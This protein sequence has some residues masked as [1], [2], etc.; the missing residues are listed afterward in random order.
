MP[1]LNEESYRFWD[2]VLKASS[3][4]G[5]ILAALFSYNQYLDTATRDARKPFLEKQ[6]EL[7]VEAADS[8]ATIATS[9]ESSDVEASKARFDRL[10]WGSLAIFDNQAIA[11]AM[12]RFNSAVTTQ[13]SEDDFA[14]NKAFRK[15]L[16]PLSE[17]I[18]HECR[19]L[20][21][22]SWFGRD[23]GMLSR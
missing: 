14:S 12:E 5:F 4:I 11:D 8:A 3:A 19:N 18:G 20:M 9:P 15:A 23:P 10:Y 7:C 6:L 17:K 21:I 2:L 16:R 22:A 13:W 1:R